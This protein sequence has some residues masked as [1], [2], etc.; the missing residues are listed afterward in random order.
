[1]AERGVS[2][3]PSEDGSEGAPGAGEGNPRPLRFVTQNSIYEV[4]E[5]GMRYRS[6]PKDS[7]RERTW[8]SKSP[9]LVDGVWHPMKRCA[10]HNGCQSSDV[11]HLH[12]WR[13]DSVLGI[14][15]TELVEDSLVIN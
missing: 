15:T 12:L 4:D 2:S 14:V 7:D 5:A 10:I 11:R 1:M 13:T 8:R 9:R 3:T 6:S